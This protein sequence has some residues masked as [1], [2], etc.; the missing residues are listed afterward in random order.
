MSFCKLLNVYINPISKLN[1][2]MKKKTCKLKKSQKVVVQI[3]TLKSSIEHPNVNKTIVIKISEDDVVTQ[4]DSPPLIILDPDDQ[5]MWEITKTVAP[6][7]GS[8]IVRPDVDD[9]FVINS[10]PI[11]NDPRE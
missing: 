11:K 10:T 4:P 5:P 1:K 6:T 7:P 8:A 9:N 3:E 2:K